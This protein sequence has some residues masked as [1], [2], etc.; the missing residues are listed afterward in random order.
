MTHGIDS[1]SSTFAHNI[2][3]PKLRETSTNYVNVTYNLNRNE[4]TVV[5]LFFGPTYKITAATI[6]P[7]SGPNGIHLSLTINNIEYKIHISTIISS[8]SR[9][10][11]PITE[12]R[13][14]TGFPGY[15]RVDVGSERHFFGFGGETGSTERKTEII[16]QFFKKSVPDFHVSNPKGVITD[17][18]I[19]FNLLLLT[20]AIGFILFMM[21]RE[22]HSFNF[23]R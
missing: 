12:R 20:P 17:E 11:V 13:K 14:V 22:K 21:H 8:A 9:K 15:A 10:I 23:K 5:S 3:P 2:K 7:A 16:R 6:L 1:F 18:A 19:D 4:N